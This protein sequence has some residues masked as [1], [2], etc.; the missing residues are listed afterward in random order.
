L[1]RLR[2]EM[3][4]SPIECVVARKEFEGLD[5]QRSRPSNSVTSLKPLRS[6]KASNIYLLPFQEMLRQVDCCIQGVI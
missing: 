4:F 2:A 5:R 3:I 6:F 1:R